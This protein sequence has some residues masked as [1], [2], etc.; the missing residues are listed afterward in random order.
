M[1]NFSTE[2]IDK[3]TNFK[4]IDDT[5]EVDPRSINKKLN[6]DFFKNIILYNEIFKEF[7]S[8]IFAKACIDQVKFSSVKQTEDEKV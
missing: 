4:N 2:E 1:S 7:L 5:E 3:F 6:K 8:N